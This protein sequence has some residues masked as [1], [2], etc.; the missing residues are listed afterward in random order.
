MVVTGYFS[1]SITFRAHIR[2]DIG[3]EISYWVV[4]FGAQSN[5]RVRRSRTCEA[6][7]YNESIA[8]ICS[9]SGLIDVMQEQIQHKNGAKGVP[10]ERRM[11]N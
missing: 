7:I 4:G 6:P 3:Y 1:P 8:R 2:G 10:E 11:N 5:I 9:L